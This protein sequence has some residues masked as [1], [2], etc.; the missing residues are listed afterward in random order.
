MHNHTIYGLLHIYALYSQVRV[1]QQKPNR[2]VCIFSMFLY[3]FPVYAEKW[4]GVHIYRGGVHILC[5]VAYCEEL[6]A[7]S[8]SD[9]MSVEEGKSLTLL[10]DWFH[11]HFVF[12]SKMF[13]L[14]L[15]WF[16]IT[17]N[18]NI[19]VALAAVS[20]CCMVIIP[21]GLRRAGLRRARNYYIV[22]T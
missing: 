13:E 1:D 14:V 18:L 16:F 6:H 22:F 21:A 7:K 20:S 4:G 12:F 19:F 15:L 2:L 11:Y 17:S 9:T 3:L 5:F 10:Q 8:Q